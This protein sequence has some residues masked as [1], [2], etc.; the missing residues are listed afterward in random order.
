MDTITISTPAFVAW[1]N[2]AQQIINNHYAKDLQPLVAPILT[3]EPGRKYLRIINKGSVYAFI[4]TENG[5]VLK[6]AS[7][8]VPAK[9]ARGNIFDA[10]N[11]LSGLG[12]YGPAYLR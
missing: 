12:P 2:G 5:D 9:H 6:A 10:N 4:N 11:G 7:W 3:I 8:K 1:I